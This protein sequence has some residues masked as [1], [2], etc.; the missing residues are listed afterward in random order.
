MGKKKFILEGRQWGNGLET[1]QFSYDFEYEISE[2]DETSSNRLSKLIIQPWRLLFEG[3]KLGVK[4]LGRFF[5]LTLLFSLVNLYFVIEC[6]YDASVHPSARNLMLLGL[7][8]LLGLL[9]FV[10]V[11]YRLYRYLVIEVMAAIYSHNSGFFRSVSAMMVERADEL[12]RQNDHI[13]EDDLRKA[14]D[15]AELFDK[16]ISGLPLVMRKMVRFVVHRLPMMDSIST[17]HNELKSGDKV[18]VSENF[19]LRMD[20]FIRESIFDSNNTNW[21]FFLLPLNLIAQILVFSNMA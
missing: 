5:L 11:L 21:A 10:V 1:K 4:G 7:C 8:L 12:I 19:Y 2:E 6:I 3:R 20:A 15:F 9:V 16:K 14:I 17:L 18:S 13:Q